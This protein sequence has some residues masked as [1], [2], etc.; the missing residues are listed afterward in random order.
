MSR[1]ALT[2]H[3]HNDETLRDLERTAEALGISIDEFAEVAIGRELA[4]VGTGLEGRL[5]RTLERLKSYT[6]ADLER[7]IQDFARGEV[8][9]EDPLRAR[10]VER[11]DV[12]GIGALFGDPVERG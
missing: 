2:L 4:S 8:D 10:R 12:H 5:A 11:Q 7:D 9:V 1:A 6:P 3:F